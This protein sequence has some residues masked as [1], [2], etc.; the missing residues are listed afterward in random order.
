MN[1]QQIREW[2]LNY[3]WSGDEDR[4]R[5]EV[6]CIMAQG[7]WEYIDAQAERFVGQ[8]WDPGAPGVLDEAT[9]FALS[10]LYECHDK[11]HIPTCPYYKEAE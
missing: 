9:E 3:A 6:D 5:R 11:P 7:G 8:A 10:A 2:L 1:E 4:Q